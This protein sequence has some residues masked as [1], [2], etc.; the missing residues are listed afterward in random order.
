MSQP[1]SQ[2]TAMLATQKPASRHT[3]KPAGRVLQLVLPDRTDHD[4]W[5]YR[6]VTGHLP[7]IAFTKNSD[8]TNVIYRAIMNGKVPG[9]EVETGTEAELQDRL[10]QRP[11]S[12]AD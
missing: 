5:R 12:G 10:M 11:Y 1:Y 8:T 9:V 4:L 2:V 7:D 3:Q 6:C